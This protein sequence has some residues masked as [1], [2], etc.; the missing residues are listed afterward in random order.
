MIHKITSSII[1]YHHQRSCRFSRE[2]ALGFGLFGRIWVRISPEDEAGGGQT[3]GRTDGRTD[4]CMYVHTYVRMNWQ[5]PPVFYR[6]SSPSGPLP[7]TLQFDFFS[8][9]TKDGDINHKRIEIIKF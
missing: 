6:T 4:G 3:D 1:I 2:L 5:I 8:N 9:E 7:K